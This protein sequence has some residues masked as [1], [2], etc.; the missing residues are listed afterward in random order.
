LHT[1][2]RWLQRRSGLTGEGGR[3]AIA[4]TM[5]ILSIELLRSHSKLAA[6]VDLM[7]LCEQVDITNVIFWPESIISTARS[8]RGCQGT[9]RGTERACQ[10]CD[11]A[12]SAFEWGQR[13]ITRTRALLAVSVCM[14]V[15]TAPKGESCAPPQLKLVHCTECAYVLTLIV[16]ICTSQKEKCWVKGECTAS[17]STRMAPGKITIAQH[18]QS[19]SCSNAA[20]CGSQPAGPQAL[21]ATQHCLSGCSPLHAAGYSA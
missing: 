4:P 6:N 12:F 3:E 16:S 15:S 5:A 21:G 10:P 7:S 20:G 2:E 18:G 17:Q 8:P 19:G 1:S 13:R 14:H 11:H 9:E